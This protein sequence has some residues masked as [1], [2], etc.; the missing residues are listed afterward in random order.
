MRTI[1]A[2]PAERGGVLGGNPITGDVTHFYFDADADASATK[3]HLNADRINPIIESWNRTGVHLMGIVHSHPWGV[4]EPSGPDVAFARQLLQRPDNSGAQHFLI[5]IVQTAADGQPSIRVFAVTRNLS[6]LLEFPFEQIPAIADLPFPIPSRTYEETFT[7]VATSYDLRRLYNSLLI[8]I[9]CG[10]GAAFVEDVARSGLRHFVLIDHDRVNTSNIATSQYYHSEVGQP[11]VEVLKRRILDINPLASVNAIAKSLDELSDEEFRTIVFAGSS[12]CPD[13]EA[14]LLCGLTDNFRCQAR[15]ARLG[16]RF[17]LPTLAAQVYRCGSGAEI[18]F[19][20]PLTTHQCIRCVLSNRY[21]AYLTHGFQNDAT[22]AGAQ[23][24]AT[25]RLN[26]TKL[27]VA[28]AILHHGT[29]HPFWGP[30][31]ARIGQRNCIQIRCDP[32][33]SEELGLFNFDEA[34]SGGK[35]EQ[36]F[37]DETIW[38]PQHPENISNGYTYNCPDCGGTGDL[39]LAVAKFGDTRLAQL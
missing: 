33:I 5:P 14:R 32:N 27:T 10:G 11:K 9:G 16:L 30:L 22:T 35:A 7:R 3:Y 2:L 15:V 34:L 6:S 1:G 20:H 4:A 39:R 26:A 28:M 37:F 21:A 31:L 18:V 25:P 29:P 19:M 38:R 12:Q 8:V 36:I 24:I 23:Y 17:Q 13:I